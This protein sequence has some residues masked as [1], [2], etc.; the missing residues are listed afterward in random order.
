MKRKNW[1]GTAAFA[2]AATIALAVLAPAAAGAQESGEP[3]SPQEI[4]VIA[5][6]PITPFVKEKGD[7]GAKAIISLKMTVEFSDLDLTR[8]SDVDRLAVRIHSVARDACGYLDR[9]Y[10]LDP[11]PDCQSRAVKDAQPQVYKAIAAAAA[12]ARQA[13]SKPPQ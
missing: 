3:S 9:T 11:D 7:N 1:M 2:R 10:P 4:E 6:R 13:P 12:A 8:A 5:P